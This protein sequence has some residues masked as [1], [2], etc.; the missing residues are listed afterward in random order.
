MK[1]KFFLNIFPARTD[2]E[3]NAD[4]GGA[5]Q[6][7]KLT[8]AENQETCSTRAR[9]PTGNPYNIFKEEYNGTLN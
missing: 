9:T 6:G 7:K 2:T 5:H 1:K 8:E 3:K 4:K